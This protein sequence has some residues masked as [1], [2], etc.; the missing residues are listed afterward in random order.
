[1]LPR[2]IYDCTSPNLFYQAV[3]TEEEV[4]KIIKENLGK[5]IKILKCNPD[6][7]KEVGFEVDKNVRL[8]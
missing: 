2:N 5:D 8:K 1:M 3:K 4:S 7:C 6:E